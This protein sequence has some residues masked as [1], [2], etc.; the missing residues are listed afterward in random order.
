LLIITLSPAKSANALSRPPTSGIWA[1]TPLATLSSVV[2]LRATSPVEIDCSAP[3]SA[4]VLP[5]RFTYTQSSAAF[6][7]MKSR[8]VGAPVLPRPLAFVVFVA[9]SSVCSEALSFT[10]D[11]V[12]VITAAVWPVD[13]PQPIAPG[14][15]CTCASVDARRGVCF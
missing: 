2:L 1:A 15:W 8:R 14:W 3:S 12:V 13:E 10:V 6:A 11:V 5:M 9:S 4:A 7:L